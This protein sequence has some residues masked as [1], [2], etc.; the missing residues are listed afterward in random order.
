MPYLPSQGQGNTAYQ[1]RW[2]Q[3]RQLLLS[4]MTYPHP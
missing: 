2:A 3:S 4:T 1:C